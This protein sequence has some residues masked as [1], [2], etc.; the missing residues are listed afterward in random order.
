[1]SSTCSAV[2]V[3]GRVARAGRRQRHRFPRLRSSPRWRH[4][5]LLRCVASHLRFSCI[6]SAKA[7]ASQGGST[8]LGVPREELL[9]LSPNCDKCHVGSSRAHSGSHEAPRRQEGSI[10]DL[11]VRLRG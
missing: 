11:V 6:P 3:V 1:M 4:G 9:G 10:L 5:L 8:T 7:R 2:P